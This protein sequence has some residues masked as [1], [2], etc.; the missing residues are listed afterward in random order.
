[1]PKFAL[2]TGASAGIGKG[3]A[4]VLGSEG[5][6]VGLV[7]RTKKNLETVRASIE[8]DGGSA[9]VYVADTTSQQDV[10]KMA[11]EVLAKEGVPDVLINNAGVYL[12]H[13]FLNSNPQHWNKMLQSNIL[14]YLHL[15]HQFLPVG[16][17]MMEHLF[18]IIM[19][20]FVK[21]ER[22]CSR[23]SNRNSVAISTNLPPNLRLNVSF[24]AHQQCGILGAIKV[25]FS[26]KFRI[27]LT[28][29][30]SNTHLHHFCLHLNFY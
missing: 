20:I 29:Q 27:L 12:P 24:L 22:F 17:P 23:V 25:Y 14:G 3:I 28:I 19:M 30:L 1:M 8:A 15:I 26:H 18:P 5:Y 16:F 10:K 13:Q 11:A 4:Q 7:A 9:S 21:S 2:I 6:K